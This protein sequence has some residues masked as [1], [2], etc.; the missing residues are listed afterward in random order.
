MLTPRDNFITKT[1]FYENEKV[2]IKFE[3][4]DAAGQERYRALAK[5]FYRKATAYTDFFIHP[6]TF[7]S[8][9]NYILLYHTDYIYPS[10]YLILSQDIDICINL[11]IDMA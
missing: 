4:W 9:L 2:N 5:Q 8:Y 1:I 3:I 7:I 11:N 10:L 6:I